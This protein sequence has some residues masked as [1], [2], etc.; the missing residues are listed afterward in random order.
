MVKPEGYTA[1]TAEKAL[2]S[3]IAAWKKRRWGEMAELCQITWIKSRSE[4]IEE[5]R[6]RFAWM[7]LNDAAIGEVEEISPVTRDITVRVD[8]NFK[9]GVASKTFKARVI[10]EAAPFKPDVNGRWGVNP[11]SMLREVKVTK[12]ESD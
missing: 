4:P 2:A 6:A 8:F 7:R 5:M 11:V 9:N 1:G 12:V 10:C 3:F